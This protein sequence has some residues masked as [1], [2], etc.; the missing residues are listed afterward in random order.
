MVYESQEVSTQVTIYISYY[1]PI[2]LWQGW[3]T[4]TIQNQLQ[5]SKL[6]TAYNKER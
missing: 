1:C 3:Q 4:V 5:D 2:T 6:N